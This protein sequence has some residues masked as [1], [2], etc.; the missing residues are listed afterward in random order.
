MAYRV[1]MKRLIYALIFLL[2]APAICQNTGA[3]TA[4]QTRFYKA[5]CGTAADYLELTNDGKYH[6]IAREHAGP[7][8][9][10]RGTWR[11][12]GTVIT[13]TPSPLL[14]DGKTVQQKPYDGTE[15]HYKGK[16]FLTFKTEDAVGIVVPTED[17]KR[18]LDSDTNTLPQY[19]FF[20]TTR[21]V[22]ASET[23]QPYP[24]RYIK[25]R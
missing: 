2:S 11:Q 12:D 10:E 22:F 4:K 9:T 13:F 17:T 23:K 6:V 24:F 25:P 20:R 5:E 3:L 15:E 16:T 18:Q 14:R 7:I 8:A 19:V 1:T 21:E